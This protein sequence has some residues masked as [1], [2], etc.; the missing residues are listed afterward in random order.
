MTGDAPITAVPYGRRLVAIT[1]VRAAL[2]LAAGVTL[3]LAACASTTAQ[4]T[5]TTWKT[6]QDIVDGLAK[7]S[8]TCAADGNPKIRTGAETPGF[9]GINCDGFDIVLVTDQASFEQFQKGQCALLDDAFWAAAAKAPMVLGSNYLVFG[10]AADGAF[11]DT[12]PPANFVSAFGGEEI[13]A[14]E[15]YKALCD[16]SDARIASAAA[17]DTTG[18]ADS[19]DADIEAAATAMRTYF[20]E[21]AAYPTSILDLDGFEPTN[22]NVVS[23]G[24][25]DAT[26]FCL[27]VTNPGAPAL[28]A[29]YDSEIATVAQ[30]ACPPA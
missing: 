25:S 8:I 5:T 6:P 24:R 7:A 19:M 21:K 12:A 23:I 1:G 15:H 10:S 13:T 18:T 27:E 20:T 22:G 9:A 4:T 16:V 3:A 11:P 14:S 29:H 30:G 2:V 28:K 17:G 26:S